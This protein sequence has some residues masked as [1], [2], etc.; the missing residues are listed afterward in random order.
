MSQAFSELSKARQTAWRAARYFNLYRIIVSGLF[1][2]LI[3][4]SSLPPP[5]AG[6]DPTVFLV[7]TVVYFA[8]A[9]L[10][11][12]ALEYRLTIF[13]AQ[14]FAQV[15]LDICAISL[16]MYASGGVTSGFGM[17][18]VVAIAGGSILTGGRLAI[19]YAAMA[20]IAV[21]AEEFYFWAYF[22]F[23]AS[24][25]THAGFL[26]ATFFTTAV[27]GHLFAQRIRETEALAAQTTIDLQNLSTLNEHIVQR[28]QSGI[29]V[30]DTHQR[31]RLANLSAG[32][33]L[34]VSAPMEQRSL[35]DVSQELLGQ[36]VLWER[37][38]ELST[39]LLRTHADA[40][41]WASF[42]SMGEGENRNTLVFLEDAL[43]MRQRAQQ[44][45]LVSLGRLTA[46]I[47]HEIRNPLGAISHAGQLLSES[48]HLSETD[49]R[50][51][52]IIR[53]HSKRVNAIIENVMKI[54]KRDSSDPQQIDLISWLDS[55]IR[56]FADRMEI[57]QE[58]IETSL[59]RDEITVR[60]D[61][62]QLHQVVWNLAENAIRHSKRSPLLSFTCGIHSD[63]QRPYLEIVDTGSGISNADA[64]QIFEPFFT[65]DHGG[66][67]LG[68]YI[69]REL[70]EGNQ[71]N[72]GLVRNSLEGCVFRINFAHPDRQQI[73]L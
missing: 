28:M 35:A 1:L 41:V 14:V 62:V 26:G 18:L 68:L 46:S 33:L 71:A 37:D 16:L 24:N 60:M 73:I 45:K 47:A 4:A 59:L 55:F 42:T 20:S 6:Y 3:I 53:G 52:E 8:G 10:A 40:E 51:T 34:G 70:C 61:P 57:S 12:F 50:M 5:I 39:R 22:Y 64:E 38:S 69:A 43:M 54:G 9:I 15:L 27:L 21:L 66:T 56:E 32:Q 72:L 36:L 63:T 23:P 11:Q 2:V 29:L 13:T 65:R 31:I 58:E 25:Y 67:G 30:L 48:S 49:L 17:L 19:L 44:S 7:T